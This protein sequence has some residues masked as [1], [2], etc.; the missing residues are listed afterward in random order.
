VDEFD[1]PPAAAGPGASAGRGLGV[2]G[3]KEE[4]PEGRGAEKARG[5]LG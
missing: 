1:P 4:I 5:T 2:M 3:D